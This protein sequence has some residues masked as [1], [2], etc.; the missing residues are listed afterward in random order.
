MFKIFQGC[1]KSN[2][3]LRKA[4]RDSLSSSLMFSLFALTKQKQTLGAQLKMKLGGV[5]SAPPSAVLNSAITPH[6]RTTEAP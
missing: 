1:R 4:M 2:Q 5:R 6:L 3:F